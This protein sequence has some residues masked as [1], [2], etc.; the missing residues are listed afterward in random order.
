MAA[1]IALHRPAGSGTG[2]LVS[3]FASELAG[4]AGVRI[5]RG[6]GGAIAVGFGAAIAVV[7]HRYPSE[8]GAAWLV[9]GAAGAS[10]WVAGGLAALSMARGPTEREDEPAVRALAAA[11]GH[12]PGSVDLA[13]T[14]AAARVAS[15]TSA[16]PVAI[17]AVVA[18]AAARDVATIGPA[19]GAVL[20]TLLAGATLGALAAACRRWAGERGRSWWLGL[21]LVP[22]IVA[23]ALLEG[24]GGEYLSIP[25]LL[26][27]AWRVLTSGP[28]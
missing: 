7:A 25:G 11:C 10:A 5:A 23:G 16:V 22:W 9:A 3:L 6:L 20:F 24:R 15:A 1:P 8:S 21:V 26:E 12:G 17:V 4:R 19:F 18:L 13:E 27:E 14:V 28:G 2:A